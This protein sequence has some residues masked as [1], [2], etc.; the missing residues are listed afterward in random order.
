M[1]QVLTEVF[2]SSTTREL[3]YLTLPIL[4]IEVITWDLKLLYIVLFDFSNEN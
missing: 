1:N 2:T 3:P 4:L